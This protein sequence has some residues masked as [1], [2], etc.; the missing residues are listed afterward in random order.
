MLAPQLNKIVL[1]ATAKNLVAG[2]W[3]ADK[4]QV[5]QLFMNNEEGREAFTNFLNDH[6]ITPV[7]LIAN[8]VEEDYRLESLPHSTGKAK[9]ELIER[10]LNQFYR[11]LV[12]RATHFIGREKDKRKDDKFLF[13]A[14]N[15][16]DFL[17][18]WMQIIQ[19]AEAELVGVYLLPMLSQ[20]LVQHLKLMAPHIL[21]CEKLSSGLRQTYLHNGRLRMSRLIPNV[22]TEQKQLGYFYLVETQ[23]TRLYL[24][25][26]RFIS[27]DITLN[28]QLVNLNDDMQQ[29]RQNFSQEPGIACEII[30]LEHVARNLNL[31]VNSLEIMPE[32][33][34]MHFLASGHV[35]DNL[36]PESLTKQ[37]QLSKIGDWIKHVTIALG[38]AGLLIGAWFFKSGFDAQTAFNETKQAT[39]LMQ[40]RYDDIA[41]DSPTSTLSAQDLKTAVA[42]DQQITAYPQS[43]RRVMMVIS[44][45]LEQSPD[46]QLN[47]LR[48]V[49]S[50]DVMIKD[51]D[52][53]ITSPSID[54]PATPSTTPGNHTT[55]LIEIAFVTAEI[56]HF[57][58]DYRHAI[59]Q[60]HQLIGHLKQAQDVAQIEI[61]QTPIN[62]SSYTN[63]R[64]N[65]A[66]PQA[67][68]AQTALFKLKVLLK[69]QTLLP[70]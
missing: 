60:M 21:L 70:Q 57:N 24:M 66:A 5:S 67:S 44:Q 56:T 17:Q 18:E 30:Q 68:N 29:M 15:N 42:L 37:H 64:G 3:H 69:P 1:C 40:H 65:T 23:K 54:T 38:V 48:W 46:I 39:I 33:L 51:E 10:K 61:L 41:K 26:K 14:L 19:T 52:K 11:G 34:H 55:Q 63:L 59:A 25:S 31:T 28:L 62:M 2:L 7:Y 43:P 4:L 13:V 36:A 53:F 58:G 20:V 16:D 47:R 27:R 35:V 22:P 8:A 9:R 6:P 45:A 32:L 50:N 12:Y 49:Q